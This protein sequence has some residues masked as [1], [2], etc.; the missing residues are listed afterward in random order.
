MIVVFK[1]HRVNVIMHPIEIVSFIHTNL[2]EDMTI[3]VLI[4]RKYSCNI[5]F[6]QYIA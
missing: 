1:F 2:N 6:L 4:N 5:E 3:A